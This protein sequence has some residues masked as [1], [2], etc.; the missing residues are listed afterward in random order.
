M[1]RDWNLVD[2]I[3]FWFLNG[4]PPFQPRGCAD[5]HDSRSNFNL[6]PIEWPKNDEWQSS[7][8]TRQDDGW[9]CEP[10]HYAPS[11]A[12][13]DI[14][15]GEETESGINTDRSRRKGFL[16]SSDA[17]ARETVKRGLANPS[18]FLLEYICGGGYHVNRFKRSKTFKWPGLGTRSD[19]NQSHLIEFDWH[20]QQHV[21]W[22][23]NWRRQNM[24]RATGVRTYNAA[25]RWSREEIDFLIAL[26]HEL[27][28]VFRLRYPA[29]TDDQILPMMITA[30]MKKEWV[31]R[32]NERFTGSIQPGS[33]KPRSERT[34]EAIMTQ[35]GRIKELVDG[36]K[37]TPDVHW[38]EKLKKRQAKAAKAGAKR[39][40]SSSPPE[41]QAQ[42]TSSKDGNCSEQT[43]SAA[44][45]DGEQFVVDAKNDGGAELNE[46]ADQADDEAEE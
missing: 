14:S 10:D 29:Y 1:Q 37:V 15:S 7:A 16:V 35:R 20:D 31:G 22:L 18:K 13:L 4:V 38:F 26:T 6:E 36:Y 44:R 11:D 28:Q 45:E 42:P 3:Q 32:F 24:V 34:A 21:D 33:T 25:Q 8:G 39:K 19:Q 27:Y 12:D 23:N 46:D 43:D 41:D 5:V 2:A 40:R 9:G 17:Q 30:K